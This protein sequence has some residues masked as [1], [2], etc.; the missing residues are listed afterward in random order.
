[1]LRTVWASDTE[2]TGKIP[3]FIG[4]WSLLTNLRFQGNSFTGPIPPSFSSLTSLTELRISDLSDGNTSLEFLKD[5]KSLNILD[6]RNNNMSGSI[7]ANFGEQKRTLPPT[8][9][10]IALRVTPSVYN[11]AVIYI[12]RFLGNNKLTGILPS[13][14]AASLLNIDLSYNELSGGFPTWVNQQNLQLCQQFHIRKSNWQCFASRIELSSEKLQVRSSFSNLFAI[15]CGGPQYTSPDEIVYERDNET[16]GVATYYVTPTNKWAVSNVGLPTGSNS[17]SFTNSWDSE[18]FQTARLSAGSLRYYG[19]G[20]QNGEYTV[21]LQFAEIDIP[22]TTWKS[23]RRRVFSIYLQGNRA[24]KDFDIQ[25]EALVSYSSVVREFKVQVSKNYLEIHL[26]WAGK[27][28]CCIPVQGTYGPSISAIS[29]TPN[30]IPSTTKKKSRTSLIAGTVVAVAVVGCLSAFAVYFYVERRKTPRAYEGHIGKGT[31]DDGRAIAVKQLSVASNQGNS[32]FVTEIAT[33]SAVQHRNLVKLHG[34]CIEGDKRLLVYEFLENRSLDQALFGRRM[35]HLDWPIRFDI[36]LGVARG[37]AYL[38]EESRLRIIHR[39]VKASNI[40]L[41]S[42]LSPKISDFG[43]AKLY[44]DNKTHIS[45]R[46]A[47]TI[48]YLAPEYAL[49]GHLTEKADVFGFG[50][51]ALEIVSGRANSDASLEEERVYLLEW[52]WHLHEN[53]REVELVDAN[54]SDFDENAVKRVIGVALLCTQTSPT[55][56]PSMSR[57]VAMLSGDVEVS[58]VTSSPGYLTDWTFNDASTF[59]SGD[60]SRSDYSYYSSSR[61]ATIVADPNSSQA[62]AAKPMLSE[63]T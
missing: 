53:N 14:K 8:F 11:L 4:N 50:V 47:G 61:G 60:P 7:P 28:T 2:L 41:D 9:P 24:L 20:L 62:N 18:L 19:L 34:C 42:D 25:A 5:M 21:R 44:D 31:L 39:D 38:H 13:Q 40:L 43:L 33:I 63:I 17:L 16:L 29:A 48:G 55:L 3:D 37:L 32:Q 46:I 35:L 54:L 22:K 45:T 52:A 51:V 27:G 30:F 59:T 26:F 36:S 12:P 49:R 56:R 15:K 6:L 57:V 1:M 58:A 23:K 10:Q